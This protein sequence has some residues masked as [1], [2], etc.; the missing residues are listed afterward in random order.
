[1][2]LAWDAKSPDG[3]WALSRVPPPASEVALSP[4]RRA[5]STERATLGRLTQRLPYKFTGVLSLRRKA[6]QVNRKDLVMALTPHTLLRALRCGAFLAALATTVLL[7]GPF[8]YA[9]FG[10][11]FEDFVAHSILFYGLTLLALLALPKMRQVDLILA[12]LALAAASELAQAVTGREM[13][14]GDL[15]GDAIGIMFAAAPLYAARFRS[16]VRTDPHTSFALLGQRDRRSA[17]R[18]A[19]PV[20]QG[21][22]LHSQIRALKA[23]N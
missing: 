17:R 19:R 3:G 20:A 7:L 23:D 8:S 21:E 2:R 22:R 6:T 13:S 14:W 10:L 15:A 12:A 16:L 4:R 1:M 18:R 5:S 9:S 11:P